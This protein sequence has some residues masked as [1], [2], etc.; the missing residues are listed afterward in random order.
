MS[1]GGS[2]NRYRF[3][4]AEGTAPWLGGEGIDL[5]NNLGVTV[6]FGGGRERVKRRKILQKEAIL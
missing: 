3:C 1:E 6:E 4:Y 2:G 5:S